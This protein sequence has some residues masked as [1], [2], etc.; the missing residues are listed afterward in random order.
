MTELYS[1]L[2]SPRGK[3]IISPN[4]QNLET[5]FMAKGT[6]KMVLRMPR[7]GGNPRLSGWVTSLISLSKGEAGRPKSKNE[8]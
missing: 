5:F 8:I 1:K 6:L 3:Q 2:Q 7:W 4:P